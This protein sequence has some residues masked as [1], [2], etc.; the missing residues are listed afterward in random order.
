MQRVRARAGK[1]TRRRGLPDRSGA[2]RATQQSKARRTGEK[3][4]SKAERSGAERTRSAVQCESLF[5][6][7]VRAWRGVAWSGVAWCRVSFV[8][9]GWRGRGGAPEWQRRGGPRRHC[10][11]GWRRDAPPRSRAFAP[12]RTNIGGAPA[13]QPI[14][15]HGDALALRGDAQHRCKKECPRDCT[16][17]LYWF[18]LKVDREAR[19]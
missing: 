14:A 4:Q 9:S 3:R 18:E 6:A 7:G 17:A 10:T 1:I 19:C 13:D 12:L 16:E 15:T 2:G 5:A 11:G 8:F